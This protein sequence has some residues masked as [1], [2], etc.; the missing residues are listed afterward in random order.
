M[1]RLFSEVLQRLGIQQT[2]SSAYP[3]ESHGALEPTIKPL[4]IQYAIA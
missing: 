3:P 1:S 2:A 4:N